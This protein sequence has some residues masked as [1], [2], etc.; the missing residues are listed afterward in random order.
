MPGIKQM[1]RVKTLA[2]AVSRYGLITGGSW[3]NESLW[4]D[5]FKVDD[6]ISK[7][8]I[9]S[10]TGKPT[11]KIY[12]NKDMHLPLSIALLK[13]QQAGLLSE[14]KTFDGAFCIREVR[15]RPGA[16]SAHS[17]GL[18]IDINAST[19]KLG[20][21]GSLSQAFGQCFIDAGFSWGARFKRPDFMHFSF[22]WE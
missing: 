20:E 7:N 12:C 22:C 5:V 3:P 9:N 18:A 21:Q 11:T 13:V 16:Q 4:L 14:L 8:W 15:G 10:A 1:P 2:E 19:N 17:Y 6:C